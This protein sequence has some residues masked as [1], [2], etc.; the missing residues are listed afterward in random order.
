MAGFEKKDAGPALPSIVLGAAVLVFLILAPFVL[1]NYWLRVLTSILMYGVVA[2][3]LNIIVGYTGYHAF[4]NSVFFGI[5]AYSTGVGMALG[6]PFGLALALTVPV[7]VVV[8]VMVGW[9]LL[10][11]SGHYFA[12]AT[13]ALNMAMMEMV[14]NVGG[15]TGGAQGLALPINPM[16]PAVLYKIIYLVMLLILAGAT[17]TVYWLDRGS[18][19]Y[20]L[21]ALR[22]SEQGAQVMG[23]NTTAMKIMAWAAS[24]SFTA[25]AGGVW[26]YWFTFIEPSSAFDI[27]ISIKGYVMMLMGG[28]GTVFGPLIGAAFLE[29]FATIIWGKF[30]KIHLLILGMLIVLVVTLMPQGLLHH[31]RWFKRRGKPKEVIR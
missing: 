27:N 28:L 10:R 13:V 23:I 31:L 20:A 4:G 5:G 3:G 6:L 12:I 17:A 25:L 30:L 8:A 16:G 2:Q 14:I 21:R 9:P 22:D 19:G 15:I 1:S 11:L 18:L 24:G 26:A 7:A 29:L